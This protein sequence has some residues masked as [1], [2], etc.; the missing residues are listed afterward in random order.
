M[1]WQVH[2]CPAHVVL[3]PVAQHDYRRWQAPQSHL[4]S[5]RRV[6]LSL[7]AQDAYG[8]RCICVAPMSS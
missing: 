7:A 2:L 3:T 8:S 1:W 4:S 6:V 5:V